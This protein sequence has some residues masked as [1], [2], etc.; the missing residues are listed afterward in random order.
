MKLEL[1]PDIKSILIIGMAGGLARITAGL[2][3]RYWPE[4]KITGI[5]NRTVTKPINSPNYNPLKMSYTRNNFEKLF[6]NNQFDVVL[7]LGRI[8]HANAN[9]R[10]QLAQR[11]DLNLM[12]TNRILDLSLKFGVKKIIIMSTWHVYGAFPDNPVFLKENTLPRA[13]IRYPELRD[14]VEMDQLAT[15]WMWKFQHEI[16]TIILRPCSIIGPQIRNSMSNYLTA[17]YMP[18]GIDYNPMT[19]FI[20]E[21]DM[22][23]VLVHSISKVPTGIYNVATDEAISIHEAK[24]IIG[25]PVIPVPIF[26]LEAAANL[27]NRTF[28]SV[29]NYLIDYLKY[30]CLLSNSELK[31]H[32]PPDPFRFSIRESLE[33]LKLE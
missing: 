10:A 30:Q 19:Q 16:E 27:I 31:Q 3:A 15:S 24:D 7:H 11:L 17:S 2:I 5:D 22:A 25:R 6:R 13:S 28:W 9:P 1:S 32:L 12:G 18:I 21:F 4:V 29:P 8:S 14:V 26:S 23:N 20:H 33:L